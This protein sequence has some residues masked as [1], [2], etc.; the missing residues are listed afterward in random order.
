[1][2][3][4]QRVLKHVSGRRHPA[5]GVRRSMMGASR[6]RLAWQHL[7]IHT[8]SPGTAAPIRPRIFLPHTP[9]TAGIV[10]PLIRVL[11]GPRIRPL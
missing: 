2:T 4:V 5:R 1:M 9:R 3:V 6:A 11:A 7:P 10:I 8:P